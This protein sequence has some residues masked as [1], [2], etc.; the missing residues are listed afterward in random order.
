MAFM[1]II[2]ILIIAICR[3]HLKRTA[4]ARYPT[5]RQDQDTWANMLMQ[6]RGIQIL[7]DPLNIAIILCLL[8]QSRKKGVPVSIQCG[9]FFLVKLKYILLMHVL[10][11]HRAQS[12]PSKRT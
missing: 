9:F 11:P 6:P 1:F 2:T 3:V 5:L 8:T 4:L 7:H 12:F 10:G